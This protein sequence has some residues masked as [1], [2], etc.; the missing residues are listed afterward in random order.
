MH[1]IESILNY[2]SQKR[3]LDFSGFRIQMLERRIQKRI[4]STGSGDLNGYYEF[5][6][7]HQHEVD[8][9]IDTLTINVSHFFRNA[10]TFEYLRKILLPDLILKKTNSNHNQIRIWSA[11][12]SNGEEPY[13][14]GIL[15]HELLSKEE[16]PIQ[17]KIFATDI[18]EK[19]LKEANK[20]LYSTN[21]LQNVKLG[22]LN[23]YF[24][25][26]EHQYE[27]NPELRE[28]V[29][30]SYY[31]LLDKKS[32]VPNESIFGGFDLVFCRNVLIYFNP[33]Y[34]KIIFNKLYR[35]L[36]NNG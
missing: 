26:K 2:I 18:D 22:I 20:G 5:L 21:S 12:C 16:L 30:F 17:L 4:L 36:N 15:L 23:K 29:D 19:A 7:K 11:G 13:S 10:I 14:A 31:D 8:N 24:T 6:C 33:E 32:Y 1:Q 3:G 34:Q 28:M 27:I 9:L 35:S 25:A